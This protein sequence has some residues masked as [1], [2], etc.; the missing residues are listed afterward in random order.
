MHAYDAGRFD[1]IGLNDPR[2]L[3]LQSI[4]NPNFASDRR[5]LSQSARADLKFVN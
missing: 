2:S 5:A 1:E 4:A 3:A